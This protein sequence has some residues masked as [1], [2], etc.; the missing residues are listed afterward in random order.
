MEYLGQ[1]CKCGELL[2]VCVRE[3]S[4]W[5]GGP[6][7]LF[8][9]VS[10]SVAALY[11]TIQKCSTFQPLS[12][13]PAREQQRRAPGPNGGLVVYQHNVS[14][15][16]KSDGPAPTLHRPPGSP[17][18]LR[19]GAPKARSGR[20]R[21]LVWIWLYA[22]CTAALPF[23]EQGALRG[24]LPCRLH[25]GGPRPDPGMVLHSNGAQ[26]GAFWQACVQEPG[27]QWAG[28]RFGW[29]EDEQEA[30]E[31]PRPHHGAFLL[32]SRTYKFSVFQAER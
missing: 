10:S 31:L 32:L 15:R 25:C 22:I 3:I 11:K 26:Y 27:L 21:L 2:G 29:E 9:C 14:C 5:W 20:V 17:L 16:R 28:A 30:E 7:P 24:Q 6:D 13:S 19:W 18:P 1:K 8:D 4:Y 12:S 23:W